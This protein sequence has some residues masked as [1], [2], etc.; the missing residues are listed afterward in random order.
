MTI[1]DSLLGIDVGSV[2]AGIVLISKDRQILHEGYGFHHGDIRKTLEKLLQELDL[3]RIEQIVATA[4]TPPSI[5]AEQR[6][7]NEIC[8]TTA[9]KNSYP[10]MGALLLVGGEKFSLTTF[11]AHGQ[12]L[13][14]TTN[15]SCAA[16]TGSFLDQQAGRL[17]LH[18]ID[19]GSTSTKAVLMDDQ[20]L[21]VGGFYTRTAG[22]PLM[23]VQN[24]FFAIDEIA[25]IKDTTFSVIQAGTT[26][27]GRKFIGKLIG[28]D[29]I[30]DEITAHARAAYQ[31]NPAVDTIIE[32]GGQD[33]KF[34]T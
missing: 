23:A 7:H 27:S 28:A 24:I 26:G 25:K 18:G 12:Y 15:T 1:K 32:I 4:S 10:Q 8:F 34:T 20:C 30:I 31:L 2:A 17:H 6:Y 3:S 9:A 22:N 33:A 21:V 11:N 13:G 5:K 19:I 16:G 29:N 14:S